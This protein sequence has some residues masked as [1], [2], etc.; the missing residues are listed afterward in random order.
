MKRNDWIFLLTVALYSFLFWQQRW[1]LNM[2]IFSGAVV[3]GTALM[4][5]Q[6]VKHR[7]WIIAAASVLIT[8]LGG[9]LNGSWLG[10]VG[11]GA[12]LLL[13]A[14]QSMHPGSSILASMLV[15]VSSVAGSFVFM[16]TDSVERRNNNLQAAQQNPNAPQRKPGRI[17][18]VI[19]SI[20]V[21]VV[22]FVIYRQSSVLFKELTKHINLDFISLGW[23]IFTA[24][25]ACIIYGIYYLHGPH[26]VASESRNFKRNLEPQLFGQQGWGDSFLSADNERFIGVL[27]FALLNVLTLLVAGGDLLFQLGERTLP[28]GITY[29]SYVHQGVGGLIVSIFLAMA[30]VLFFFRGRLNFDMRY[31]TLRILA[32][33]W[34]AQNVL[35]LV[36]TGMR[37]NMYSLEF[38]LTYRR[39]G[40]YFYL[41]LTLGGLITTAI[42]VMNKKTNAWLFHANT[43]FC[44]VAF[45]MSTLISWDR[46]ITYYNVTYPKSLDRAYVSNLTGANIDLLAKINRNKAGVGK[47]QGN[48][49]FDEHED[50][51]FDGLLDVIYK[52]RWSDKEK[53]SV[54]LYTRIYRHL[55]VSRTIDW[56]SDVYLGRH[57]ARQLEAMPDFGTDTFLYIGKQNLKTLYYFNGFKNITILDASDNELTGLGEIARFPALRHLKLS[58]NYDLRS[59]KGIEGCR[60]L[61]VLDISNVS[62]QNFEALRQLPKLKYVVVSESKQK[63]T[64]LKIRP[65]L[66]VN[67]Q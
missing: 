1:G 24:I 36:L 33:I 47:K 15:S 42:K 63:E 62:V 21:V 10:L 27:V 25:G 54:T 61:E 45:S 19:I 17:W 43:W 44:F 3:L 40:V 57:V 60:N 49:S 46:F 64:I 65:D 51:D 37:S 9:Y 6:A 58:N 31:K 56:R 52:N 22:F 4:N 66:T 12:A 50:I 28:E 67:E 26:D 41:L 11:N 8:G 16:I 32:L 39:L 20:A 13:L 59:L 18:A 14:A 5:P 38:G 7:G 55:Y 29:T 2:L 53:F 23:I 48:S 34:L 35:L 30:L